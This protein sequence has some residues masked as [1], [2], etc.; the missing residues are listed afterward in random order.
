MPMT[1]TAQPWMAKRLISKTSIAGL[2]R[3]ELIDLFFNRRFTQ[4]HTDFIFLFKA[5]MK[6]IT[7][8]CIERKINI[9]KDLSA[10]LCGG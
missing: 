8:D 6:I 5:S 9:S 1:A 7:P 2:V 3:F 10:N 4:T